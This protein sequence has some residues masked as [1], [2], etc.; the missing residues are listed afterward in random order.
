MAVKVACSYCGKDI[1]RS[2]YSKAKTHFCCNAH[3]RLWFRMDEKRKE[4]VE[5]RN[6]IWQE[7]RNIHRLRIEESER[8]RKKKL[9]VKRD[10]YSAVHRSL[11]IAKARKTS[12]TFQYIGCSPGFLRNHLESLFLPGMSWENRGEW[13]IDHIVPLSWWDL[14]HHREHLLIANHWTNLQPLWS[15]DN[16][17]KGNRFSG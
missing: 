1:E 14:E 9:V 13:H 11:G 7:H 3:F 16:I 15:T 6:K 17:R 4:R 10:M 5:R 12:H 2:K 8:I